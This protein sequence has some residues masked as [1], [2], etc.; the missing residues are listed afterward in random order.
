MRNAVK[1]N[2]PVRRTTSVSSFMAA[3]GINTK[4]LPQ[5]LDTKFAQLIQNWNINADGQLIKR[6]GIKKLHEVASITGYSLFKH[7]YNDVYIVGYGT[8]VSAV[9][10]IAQTTIVIKSNFSVNAPVSGNVYGNYFFV[11][12]GGTEKVGRISLTLAY[13][14]QTANYTVGALVTGVTS[15]ATAVILE[16]TDA[17]ATGT[18]ML[19]NITG[20]FQ[21]G[22]IITDSVTGSAKANGVLTYVYAEVTAAPVA[23]Y[24]GITTTGTSADARLF[25]GNLADDTSAFQS[26]DIDDGSNPPFDTWTIG[27]VPSDGFKRFSKQYGQLKTI[28]SLGSQVVIGYER[29]RV[30]FRISQLGD[31][32]PRLNL[33]NDWENMQEGM[34]ENAIETSIGLVFATNS[35][36]KSLVAAGQTNIPYSEQVLELSSNI[37]STYWENVDF[38]N[39][40]IIE[41]VRQNLIYFSF[42]K[43]SDRNNITFAYNT[44]TKSLVEYTLN[45]D[46]LAKKDD[47]IYGA[48][49]LD[50]KLYEM[51]TGSDDDSDPIPTDYVQEIATGSLVSKYDLDYFLTQALLTEG[52]VHLLKLS[53]FD[54]EGDFDEDVAIHSMTGVVPL[55]LMRGYSTAGYGVSGYGIGVAGANVGTK[56]YQNQDVGLK[57][58][59]RVIVRFTSNDRLP[60]AINFFS[61]NII[62]RGQTMLTNNLPVN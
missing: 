4:D 56:V 13:D 59:Y 46:G 57:E 36:F 29:G 50:G 52:S 48:S 8:T 28:G 26:S 24:I 17:G 33:I 31:A 41:D 2:T 15:G 49:S 51:F 3:G 27:T 6:K 1:L 39:L 43:D 38:T 30:A 42:R 32:T 20:I 53:T 19:G 61:A 44:D 5:L 62:N 14:T 12:T 47:T 22:E 23:K 10:L 37:D 21:T 40:Q 35:G 54:L 55:E 60:A 16:D 58:F 9:D 11:G 45:I 25:V 18:L 7:F 34:L